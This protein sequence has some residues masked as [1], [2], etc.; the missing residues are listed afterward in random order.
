[1]PDPAAGR[2]PGKHPAH[3]PTSTAAAGARLGHA[4]PA[5]PTEVPRSPPQRS[6]EGTESMTQ[7]EPGSWSPK[8]QEKH[9]QCGKVRPSAPAQPEQPHRPAAAIRLRPWRWR[10]VLP[11]TRPSARPPTSRPCVARRASPLPHGRSP[12]RSPWWRSS[13]SR[14][15]CGGWTRACAAG[16]P[17]RADQVL[18]AAGTGLTLP[19]YGAENFGP[20]PARVTCMVTRKGHRPAALRRLCEPAIVYRIHPVSPPRAGGFLRA[21]ACEVVP[22]RAAAGPGGCPCR[23]RAGPGG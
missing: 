8:R 5:R 13:C 7:V 19:Y 4:S 10:D 11:C 20:Q 3:G 17:A 2:T 22:G 6:C 23:V 12:T 14:S 9:P 18:T 1:M 16:G 15:G 21:P